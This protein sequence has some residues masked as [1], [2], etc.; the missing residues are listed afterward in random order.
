MDTNL[1][2]AIS[3]MRSKIAEM[4]KEQKNYKNQRRTVRLV[5][6]RTMPA[7]VAGENSR[8]LTKTLR[9]WYAAYG[10]LGGK[11]F[12]V[13]ENNAKPLIHDR[14][15]YYSY[16]DG[17]KGQHYT[18][19]PWLHGKHPLCKYLSEI[20]NV[21]ETFG[22]KIKNYEENKDPWGYTIKTPSTE[23]YEEIVCIGE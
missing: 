12:E 22:Y 2:N 16:P 13:T 17:L 11:K 7:W 5:G 18:H 9:I 19:Y 21:L 20:N 10:I 1:K 8:E 3:A 4:E 6:E 23:N 14:D 15:M